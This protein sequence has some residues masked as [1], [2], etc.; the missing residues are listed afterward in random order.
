M[1]LLINWHLIDFFNSKQLK[2]ED[3]LSSHHGESPKAEHSH[4][5]GFPK[6]LKMII[7]LSTSQV[8]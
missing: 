5:H 2:F 6:M 1:T 8:S 7:I 4:S 3:A